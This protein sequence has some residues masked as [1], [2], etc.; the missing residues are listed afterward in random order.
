MKKSCFMNHTLLTLGHF[1]KLW[2]SL[3]Y[4]GDVLWT[5][6]AFFL[7]LVIFATTVHFMLECIQTSLGIDDTSSYCCGNT[8]VP[9]GVQLRTHFNFTLCSLCY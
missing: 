7:L 9:P 8:N 3:K 4:F 6:G 5:Y 1:Y 2:F